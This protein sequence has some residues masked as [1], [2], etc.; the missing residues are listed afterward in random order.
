[1]QMLPSTTKE[2]SYTRL[3][4]GHG[5]RRGVIFTHRQKKKQIHFLARYFFS[6]R[7]RYGGAALSLYIPDQSKKVVRSE[8]MITMFFPFFPSLNVV[9]LPTSVQPLKIDAVSSKQTLVANFRPKPEKFT[10][11]E[12]SNS[13]FH[14]S[15]LKTA[16]IAL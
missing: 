8:M 9:F 14:R 6:E 16:L 3:H 7:Q 11:L 12:D 5:H 4:E 2:V 10:F 1:M 13:N 15:P